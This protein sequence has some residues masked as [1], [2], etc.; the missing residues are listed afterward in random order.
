VVKQF[1]RQQ[2]NLETQ[3]KIIDS[4]KDAKEQSQVASIKADLDEIK[5][6]LPSIAIPKR[7]EEGSFI[8]NYPDVK[9]DIGTVKNVLQ[10][11]VGSSAFKPIVP[12]APANSPSN[13][14]P[15][16]LSDAN[17]VLPPA[18]PVKVSEEALKKAQSPSLPWTKSA[19]SPKIIAK[20]PEWLE[21][22]QKESLDWIYGKKEDKEK[23]AKVDKEVSS[24]RPSSR[25][26]TPTDSTNGSGAPS[27]PSPAQ[28]YSASFT[29]IAN[30]VKRGETPSNVRKIDDSPM[31]PDLDGSSG[32]SAKAPAKPWEKP[33][34]IMA[35]AIDPFDEKGSS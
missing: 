33:S 26:V 15:N 9:A 23:E 27:S 30:M 4:V 2:S 35:N 24:D 6:L 25:P 1:V 12:A 16:I 3:N 10:Q 5:S 11:S 29:E 7:L 21:K 31:E 8:A 34:E 17:V 28:P 20:K 22:S 19:D 13:S 14:N 32:D 18:P